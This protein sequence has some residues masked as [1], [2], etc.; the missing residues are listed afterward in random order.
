MFEIIY[1]LICDSR[2]WY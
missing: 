1:L 2:D